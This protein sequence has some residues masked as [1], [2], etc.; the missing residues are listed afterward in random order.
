MYGI[1]HYQDL[2]RPEIHNT[3][4]EHVYSYVESVR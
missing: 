4:S 1:L 3:N 2:I